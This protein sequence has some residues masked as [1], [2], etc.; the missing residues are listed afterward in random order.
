MTLR[1]GSVPY[2]N[3]KP[4]VDWFHSPDCR[5]DVEIVYA[6]PSALATMLENG[7]LDVA[8]VSVFEALRNPDLTILPNISI[9]AYGAVKSVRLFAK[10]PLH[11]L[12]SVALD[13]SSLTSSALTRILLAEQFGV[14]PSFAPHAP[15]L[16]TMLVQYDAA[17]I[18]GDL[19]LFELLPD[20]F[21]YDLGSGWLELTGLP[22]VYACWI[23]PQKRV[24]AQM[25]SL[26]QQ[27][28]NWGI[29]H[30]DQL[31]IKWSQ[32]MHIPFDRCWDYLHC[33][34]NYDLT[35]DQLEGL[36][37]FQ[38]KCVE[39]GLIAQLRPLQIYASP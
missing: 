39:H 35:D 9:S 22:F 25:L 8:N 27:A 6:V 29:Q 11:K 18:I 4:L 5:V 16:R 20:T 32:K 3:A 7:I 34:M 10:K 30:L 28:K 31:A 2:L 14:H 26:L 1:I 36:K 12:A 15:D 13:S 21:V 37:T 19:R 33:V 17:L 38:R 24:S 23:A